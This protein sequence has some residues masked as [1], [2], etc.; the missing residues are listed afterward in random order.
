MAP[1]ENGCTC[2]SRC[3]RSCRQRLLFVFGAKMHLRWPAKGSENM[4]DMMTGSMLS[5]SSWPG[6]RASTQTWQ[7]QTPPRQPQIHHKGGG[8]GPT[9]GHPPPPNPYQ[10]VPKEKV[11]LMQRKPRAALAPLRGIGVTSSRPWI[12]CRGF[13]AQGLGFGV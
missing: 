3:V 6:I 7:Q 8:I 9:S 4:E 2:G 1:E 10:K 13:R 12:N 5:A 11:S